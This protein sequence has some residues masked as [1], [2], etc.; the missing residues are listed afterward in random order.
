[1]L[2]VLLLGASQVLAAQSTRIVV[3]PFHI[4][5]GSQKED[6]RSFREHVS[7]TVRA[8]I[9]QLGDNFTI[10]PESATDALLKGGAAPETDEQAQSIGKQAGADLVVY[11]FLSGAESRYQMRAVLWDIHAGRPS[12]ATDLKVENIHGLSGVLQVFVSALTRRLHGSPRLRFYKTDPSD[13]PGSSVTRTPALVALP[14]NLAPWQSQKIQGALAAVDIGDMDGDSKNE[15]VFL[16]DNEITISRFEGGSLVPLTKFRQFETR[17]I[18]AEAEDLDGDGIC[19]LLLCYQTPAG[20]ESAIIKYVNRN[21]KIAAKFPDTILRTV[22]DPADRKHRILVGQRTDVDDI[23]SGEM[24]RFR[25]DSSGAVPDGKLMLPPGTLLLS[26]VSGQLGKQRDSVQVIL[27]QDQR[28]MIFDRE[29]RLLASLTDKLY[30]LNRQI[31]I[32]VK[33]RYRDI[34]CPGR[35]LMA[36]SSGSG[37]KELLVA[38][39]GDGSS[40]IQALS[41]D[42]ENVSEKW[43]TVRSEGVISD[44]RIRDF[45]NEGIQSLVLIL[46]EPN[47]FL[48]LSGP[49]SVVYAYDLIP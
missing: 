27:N 41:W 1:V 45:K 15:T 11:G 36:D 26:Y 38:K 32:R 16:E 30:G 46:V 12:V 5:P 47:P 22:E 17:Y 25:V 34:V 43:K 39:Q 33:N 13:I 35:L 42:G 44:F 4:A 2:I 29:N 19:E 8:E 24:V 23:F 40:F 48:A 31:R 18:S 7:K 9:G 20:I 21:F 3:L 14:R 10:E 37:E 6:I 28:L 49:H